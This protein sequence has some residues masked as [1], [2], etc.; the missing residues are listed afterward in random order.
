MIDFIDGPNGQIAYEWVDGD[1]D[2]PPIVFIHGFKS[3]MM[4]S[5]AEFLK[6]YCQETGRDFLRFDVSA[7]GQSDGDMMDFTIGKAIEDAQF[8][9]TEALCRRAIIVGSSMGGW[10]GLRLM[11]LC[12]N[13]ISGFVGI[14]A[15]PDFTH[16]ISES[17]SDDQKRHLESQ[18]FISEDS[19]YAEPYIFTQK[20]FDD[21]ANHCL[22]NTDMK[23]DIPVT[24]LQGK[25]DSSVPWQK[26]QR[27]QSAL[28]G[29]ATIHFI[30][31]GDHS[32][33]RPQD[34]ELLKSAI[35]QMSS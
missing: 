11:Q 5:K 9:L 34:L 15:A 27:I 29:T 18:G 31:D 7:H 25:K 22:L 1:T 13:K 4:G 28:G 26:A 10:V 6:Q 14:A 2:L 24:L 23:T 16:E 35:E 3:D 21:G 30:D 12:P 19:G 17:L 32:L 20:L 8:M 33:S